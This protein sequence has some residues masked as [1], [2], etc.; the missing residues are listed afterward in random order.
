[1][2]KTLVFILLFIFALTIVSCSQ[3]LK[4]KTTLDIVSNDSSVN[5]SQ[6]NDPY[7]YFTTLNIYEI[8]DGEPSEFDI[9]ME[10]NPIDKKMNDDSELALT[11]GDLQELFAKYLKI[12]ETELKFSIKNL[13]KY[14]SKNDSLKLDQSQKAWEINFNAV[15]EFDHDFIYQNNIALGTQYNWNSIYC[16][17]EQYRQR[18]FHIKYMTYL[19]E[20][21]VENPQQE[22]LWNI[23]HE[24]I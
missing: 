17:I 6:I 21:Y 19:A 22:Q 1:M 12:W 9:A 13:K 7:K 10:N 15:N 8:W 11:T 18:V 2:K 14:C 20:N 24:I 3:I 5:E 23:Y 4:N 16:K